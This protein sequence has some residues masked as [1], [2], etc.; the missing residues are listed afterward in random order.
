MAFV[1]S[2][3]KSSC[4]VPETALFIPF[5]SFSSEFV[6][7]KAFTS[8]TGADLNMEH[9]G[10]MATTASALALQQHQAGLFRALKIFKILYISAIL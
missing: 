3:P 1:P 8:C 5:Q 10:K 2:S 9:Q 4:A 7:S 6:V